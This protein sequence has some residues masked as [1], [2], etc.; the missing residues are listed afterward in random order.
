MLGD[1]E[2]GPL[3]QPQAQPWERKGW[4]QTS[5]DGN[6]AG[7]QLQLSALQPALC[8]MSGVLSGAT[9]GITTCVFRG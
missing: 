4:V 9:S 5:K 3:E 7:A 1:R 8:S 6:P 2:A